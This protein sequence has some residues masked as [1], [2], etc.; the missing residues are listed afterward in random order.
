M[1]AGEAQQRV[2][3]LGVGEVGRIHDAPESDLAAGVV[4]AVRQRPAELEQAAG[5]VG[6]VV[7][8]SCQRSRGRLCLWCGGDGMGRRGG[9]TVRLGAG[10]FRRR[11][12]RQA[13]RHERG[14][15]RRAAE[16]A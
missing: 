13:G 10:R 4:P 16:A 1:Q 8:E 5:F 2:D 11:R 6:V 14:D 3:L 9:R 7:G 15:Q 12:P